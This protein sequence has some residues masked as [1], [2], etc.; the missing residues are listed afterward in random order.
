MIY[1][2]AEMGAQVNTMDNLGNTPLHIAVKNQQTTS[3]NFL[4]SL[5][6]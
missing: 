2:L 5:G 3:V 1:M 6:A 4:I